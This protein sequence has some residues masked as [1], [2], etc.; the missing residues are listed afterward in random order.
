MAVTPTNPT[1]NLLDLSSPPE[2]VEAGSA[3]RSVNTLRTLVL[4][5]F[6]S[7]ARAVAALTELMSHTD[8]GT[9]VGTIV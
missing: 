9:H 1:L 5:R 2:P 6:D 7:L 4:A 8:M 3:Y